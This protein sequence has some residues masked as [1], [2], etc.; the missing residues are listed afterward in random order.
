MVLYKYFLFFLTCKLAA[1]PQGQTDLGVCC[2]KGVENGPSGLDI[3]SYCK[4]C[5]CQGDAEENSHWQRKR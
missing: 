4:L 1:R 3:V 2:G 5:C